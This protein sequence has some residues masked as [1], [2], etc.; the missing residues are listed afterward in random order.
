MTSTLKSILDAVKTTIDDLAIDEL[1]VIEIQKTHTTKPKDDLPLPAVL[2]ATTGGES[3]DA[4]GGWS[5]TNERNLI[6]YPVLIYDVEN[7]AESGSIDYT[8]NEM[9]PQYIRRQKYFRSFHQK[10]LSGVSECMIVLVAPDPI[11]YPASMRIVQ[12]RTT[13]LRL[14]VV[15]RETRSVS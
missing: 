14:N 8:E 15:C 1:R 11:V 7:A 12:T 4:F 2:I 3:V 10:R 5:S 6:V 9:D 13:G